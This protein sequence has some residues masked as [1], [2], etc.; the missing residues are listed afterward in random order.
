[1]TVRHVEGVN[2]SS[3]VR[4]WAKDAL[5]VV[6]HSHTAE[7]CPLKEDQAR[8]R[9]YYRSLMQDVGSKL[10]VKVT[11][12]YTAPAQHMQFLVLETDDFDHLT[13]FLRPLYRIGEVQIIPAKKFTERLT[14]LVASVPPVKHPDYYCM[15]CRLDFAENERPQHE[16]HKYYTQ[17]EM[18][19][20]W[21]HEYAGEAGGG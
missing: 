12:A 2:L 8:A 19:A 4:V 9:D 18:E 10:G 11:A 1:V 15:N 20:I 21:P 13:S 5:F 3:P 16:G 7:A 17:N 14:E 6:I